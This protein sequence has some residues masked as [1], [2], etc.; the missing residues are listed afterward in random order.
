MGN[1]YK[2]RSKCILFSAIILKLDASGSNIDG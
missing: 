2:M 1:N